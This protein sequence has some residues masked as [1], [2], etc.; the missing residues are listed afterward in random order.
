MY[1]DIKDMII[2]I[3]E[4]NTKELIRYT[5]LVNEIIKSNIT[6][7]SIIS[8]VFDQLL[9]LTFVDEFLLKEVYYKLLNYTMV[10]DEELSIDYEKI[11]IEQFEED[12]EEEPITYKKTNNVK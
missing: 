7:E 6:D 4:L 9:S 3:S 10:F 12:Y 2:Y 8:S 5:K 1:E 11:Y